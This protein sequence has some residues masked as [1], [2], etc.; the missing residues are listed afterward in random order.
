VEIG[1]T[2]GARVQVREVGPFD[3]PITVMVG[4]QIRALGRDVAR[5]VR[6]RPEA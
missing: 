6:V 4:S 3:G 1:L 5:Q 2:P